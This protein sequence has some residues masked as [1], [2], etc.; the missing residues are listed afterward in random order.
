MSEFGLIEHIARRFATIDRRGWEAIGDDCTVLPIVGDEVMVMTTDMLV[1]GV[2]FLRDKMSATDIGYK[3]LAVNLSDVAAMGVRPEAALLSLAL[4]AD[5]E[6]EWAKEFI[7]GFHSL[8]EAEGVA[9]VGGDTTSSADGVVINVVAIG[10]GRAACVKRRSAAKV[11]DKIYVAGTLGGSAIGLKDLIAGRETACALEHRRPVAQ[12]EEGVWLGECGEV[13][14][15]MDLSDGLAS[16]LCHIL[17]ASHCA[18]EVY[19]EQIPARECDVE[20]AVCGGEDYKLLFTVS[21]DS[22]AEF[23][24]DFEARFGF[25]PYAVGRIVEGEDE[26]IRWIENGTEINPQWRGF[27]HF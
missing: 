2:H 4:P 10:R 25:R 22:A 26:S 24:Q 18:A 3:S 23:E 17:K 14:A 21:S 1:E 19:V 16:D 6:E 27:S 15:M 12:I 11:G 8:A 20:S 13:H 9:L 5:A 7:E